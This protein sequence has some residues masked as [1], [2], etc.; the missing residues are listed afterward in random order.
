M[1][2]I[3]MHYNQ[4]KYQLRSLMKEMSEIL[5]DSRTIKD[6]MI[7]SFYINLPRQNNKEDKFHLTKELELMKSLLYINEIK[8]KSIKNIKEFQY[9][10][11]L[12]NLPVDLSNIKEEL[13]LIKE[14]YKQEKTQI[15]SI[16]E[17]TILKLNEYK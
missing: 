2:D 9:S 8:P 13:L 11:K 12:L 15:K 6:L 4:G 7:S 17:E 1:I 3:S 16:T 10:T 14:E 5:S